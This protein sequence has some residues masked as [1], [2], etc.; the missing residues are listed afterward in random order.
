MRPRARPCSLSGSWDPGRGP[1]AGLLRLRAGNRSRGRGPVPSRVA[2]NSLACSYT[3]SRETPSR[4]A[5]SKRRTTTIETVET[6]PH[7][8][9]ASADEGWGTVFPNRSEPCGCRTGGLRTSES[10]RPN[11]PIEPEYPK[12]GL[13]SNG[14]AAMIAVSTG[15]YRLHPPGP[16]R[17]RLGGHGRR[18]PARVAQ[19]REACDQPRA[20]VDDRRA[21]NRLV[22]RRRNR[23]RSGSPHFRPGLNGHPGSNRSRL[24]PPQPLLIYGTSCPWPLRWVDRSNHAD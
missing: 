20:A 4:R 11:R 23:R 3:H 14:A 24:R 7:H 15:P 16:P 17:R 12:S 21:L 18:A 8:T 5:I 19:R 22:R 1:I 2:P 10:F 13:T 9:V 6:A